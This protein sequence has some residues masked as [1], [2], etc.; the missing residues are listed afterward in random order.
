MEKII[1]RR[2]EFIELLRSLVRS[3]NLETAVNIVVN[4]GQFYYGDHSMKVKNRKTAR[5]LIEE[6]YIN[7]DKNVPLKNKYKYRIGSIHD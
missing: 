2:N 5:N 4:E 6:Y 3:H 1:K 7:N